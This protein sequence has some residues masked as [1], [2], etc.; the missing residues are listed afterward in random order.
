MCINL[1][2]ILYLFKINYNLLF[3]EIGTYQNAEFE[4]LFNWMTPLSNESNGLR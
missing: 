4:Y 3:S 2:Q 1:L